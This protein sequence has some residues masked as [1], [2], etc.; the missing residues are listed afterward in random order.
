MCLP[1]QPLYFTKGRYMEK[2]SSRFLPANSNECRFSDSLNS[3]S[4]RFLKSGLDDFRSGFPPPS[5][6]TIIRG[7][8]GLSPIILQ[9]RSHL[10]QQRAGKTSVKP[11]CKL[12]SEVEARK[13]FTNDTNNHL[14]HCPQLLH[15]HLNDRIFP[16]PSSSSC[17]GAGQHEPK[18][19]KTLASLK[20]CQMTEVLSGQC[21]RRCRDRLQPG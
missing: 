2:L 13:E 18:A 14:S 21:W 12:K 4:W 3:Q 17:L 20:M 9:S 19:R 1:S 7:R 16:K 10:S 8:K 15:S 5:D 6:N 11:T